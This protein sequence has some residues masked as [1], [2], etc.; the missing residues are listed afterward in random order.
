V[1]FELFENRYHTMRSIGQTMK[2]K[3]VKKFWYFQKKKR[4]QVPGE[5]GRSHE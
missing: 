1:F 3:G 4:D 2:Y 5:C